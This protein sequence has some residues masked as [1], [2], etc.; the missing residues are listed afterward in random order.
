[1]TNSKNIVVTDF[2]L[3]QALSRATELAT[4]I[5]NKDVDK[6]VKEQAK[7]KIGVLTEYYAG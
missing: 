2:R 3:K 6:A 5:Q 1:M 7:L 4:G